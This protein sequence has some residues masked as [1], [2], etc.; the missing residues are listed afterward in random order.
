[1]NSE[2]P[3][4]TGI[5]GGTFNPVHMGHLLLARAAAEAYELSKVLL[6]PCASPPHKKAPDLAASE[7][8]LAMLRAVAES[9]LLLD[10]S[11]IEINRGG[12]SYAIDTVKQIKEEEP[13]NELFFVVGSDTLVE[14]HQWRDIYDLLKLCRFVA[15]GRPGVLR[16]GTLEEED[17]GLRPPWPERLLQDARTGRRIDISSSEIR[18]RVAEGMS[19]RYLVPPEVEMY[20]AEHGLYGG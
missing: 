3:M 11:D 7:H 14:L 1:M 19:I 4:R 5:L 12:I 10:V 20:I 18:Y 9:D 15:F 17:L 6:I 16:R 2:E 8:R 13:G